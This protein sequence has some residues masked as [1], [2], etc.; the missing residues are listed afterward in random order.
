MGNDDD[1]GQDEE[2]SE[3]MREEEHEEYGVRTPKIG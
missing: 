3:A 1:E 2:M